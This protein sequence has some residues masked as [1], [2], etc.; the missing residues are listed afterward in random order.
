M[1]EYRFNEDIERRAGVF[2]LWLAHEAETNVELEGIRQVF[3]AVS[4]D[5]ATRGICENEQVQLL[6]GAIEGHAEAWGYL[7]DYLADPKLYLTHCLV[8]VE[9]PPQPSSNS[10]RE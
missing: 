8:A 9:N 5:I 6:Y 1:S 7:D 4:A 2:A 10:G 3:L